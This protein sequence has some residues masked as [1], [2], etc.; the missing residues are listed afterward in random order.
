MIFV[1]LTREPVYLA[2]RSAEE[3]A[4][5]EQGCDRR[6][7]TVVPSGTVAEVR[8]S[9]NLLCSVDDVEVHCELYSGVT[10]LPK[11]EPGTLFIVSEEVRRASGRPDVVSVC[12]LRNN[13][14]TSSH[15]LQGAL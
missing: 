1:N 13:L 2:R 4:R 14:L 6:Y 7:I 12:H 10:G 15:T 11:S 5:V 9:Q 8:W 3:E